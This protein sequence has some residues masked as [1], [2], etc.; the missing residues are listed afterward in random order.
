M[1][2]LSFVYNII[3]ETLAEQSE[4][5]EDDDDK[6]IIKNTLDLSN[7]RI[8]NGLENFGEFPEEE[9]DKINGNV[10][11]NNQDNNEVVESGSARYRSISVK[12]GLFESGVEAHAF[13][14]VSPKHR[15]F[16]W[17]KYSLPDTLLFSL[18]IEVRD[19]GTLL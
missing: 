7:P 1:E 18:G 3:N 17:W 13:S 12:S 6:T 15:F 5:E 16:S 11:G 10:N 2:F 14:V 8:L 9:E 19:C 4:L